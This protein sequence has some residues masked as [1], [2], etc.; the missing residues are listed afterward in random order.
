M[1]SV[2]LSSPQTLNLYAYCINDP[3]NLIDPTGLGFLS[4]IAK[5][6]RAVKK[7]LKWVVI[8]LAVVFVVALTFAVFSLPGAQFLASVFWKG[9]GLLTTFMKKAG[10]MAFAE[11][12]G[13]FSVGLTGQ[14]LAGAMTVGA[15]ANHLEQRRG[16]QD[17]P[18]EIRG[19]TREQLQIITSAIDDLV[20]RIKTNDACAKRLGGR[21]KALKAIRES[22]VSV[23]A[24][25]P[26]LVS[27]RHGVVLNQPTMAETVGKKIKLGSNTLL[28]QGGSIK[29]RDIGTGQLVE[30]PVEPTDI[31]E[32]GS[33]IG[34]E[35]GHRTKSKGI[36]QNDAH[37]KDANTRNT[38]NVRKDCGYK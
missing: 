31:S 15:I 29:T 30:W 2:E 7:V 26:G 9:V 11:A 36:V 27:A 16:G 13:G 5:I 24:L 33:M 28:R 35:V 20:N 32:I 25:Y 22:T 38:E 8:V 34:H 14:I 12:G 23:E 1:R 3:V 37:N 18:K 17:R 4:F 21:E 19:A 6:F 10:I